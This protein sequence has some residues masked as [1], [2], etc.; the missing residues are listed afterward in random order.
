LISQAQTQNH[1]LLRNHFMVGG[2]DEA[3]IAPNKSGTL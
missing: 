2:V 1:P 3:L